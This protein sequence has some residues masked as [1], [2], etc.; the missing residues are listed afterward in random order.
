VLTEKNSLAGTN[1]RIVINGTRYTIPVKVYIPVF[2][3]GLEGYYSENF[4]LGLFFIKNR[5]WTI[6]RAPDSIAIGE[7]WV[8][9]NSE[10]VR[11]KIL[12]SENGRTC[13]QNSVR[14][15]L[16]T[17]ENNKNVLSIE[18]VAVS[19]D[20]A[21]K[22]TLAIRFSPPLKQPA[23][24]EDREVLSSRFSIFINNNI[25]AIQGRAEMTRDGDTISITVIP[26][27]PKWAR[28]SIIRAR[29]H[30]T[31]NKQYEIKSTVGLVK[32]Q[33]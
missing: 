1:S 10:E 20:S 4:F 3:T 9:T 16:V 11:Y 28:A 23:D 32:G 15:E 33:E 26:E 25:L 27:K 5:G 7:E 19:S 29:I 21:G 17:F 22:R 30:E 13:V 31:S 6:T 14:H 18:S 12:H 2:F 8:I 24:M